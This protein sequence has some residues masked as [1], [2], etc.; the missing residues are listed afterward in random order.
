MIRNKFSAE[1]RDFV[2]KCLT[3]DPMKR[4][5]AAQLLN[6]KFIIDADQNQ[7]DFQKFV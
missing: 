2:S 5:S 3:K 1:F 7:A 6:H 4:P